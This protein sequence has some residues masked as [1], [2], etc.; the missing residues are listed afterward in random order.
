MRSLFESFVTIFIFIALTVGFSMGYIIL[1]PLILIGSIFELT[2]SRIYK[3]KEWNRKR[4]IS[5]PQTKQSGF[6]LESKM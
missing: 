6:F 1:L 2:K 5:Y 4:L 3:L